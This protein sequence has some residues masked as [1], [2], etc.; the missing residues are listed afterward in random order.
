MF[1]KAMCTASLVCFSVAGFAQ[2][3]GSLSKV[4]G[5]VTVNDGVRVVNGVVGTPIADGARIVTTSTGTATIRLANG[6]VVDLKPNQAIT[7]LNNNPCGGLLASVQNTVG[8]VEAGAQQFSVGDGFIVAT[9]V[10]VTIA[11]VD[12]LRNRS[13]RLSGS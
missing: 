2:S 5:T 12:A 11:V 13:R 7:V 6:C 10:G 8:P 1:K 4:D 3:I 9:G